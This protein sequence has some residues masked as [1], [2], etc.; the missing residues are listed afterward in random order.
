MLVSPPRNEYLCFQKI[1]KLEY[2]IPEGFPD[3]ATDLV[4]RL[5]V[6]VVLA[7]SQYSCKN[8]RRQ[9]QGALQELQCNW[10]L[11]SFLF[12]QVLDPSKRL[13]CSQMG[14]YDPLRAHIF[15]DGKNN[16]CTVLYM[17]TQVLFNWQL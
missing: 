2:S 11:F 1:T 5:L 10:C 8:G 4:T 9:D 15:F 7:Q 17:C 16:Q 14:G 3:N 6:G 12:M 13:G